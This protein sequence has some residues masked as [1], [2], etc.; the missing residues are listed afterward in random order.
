MIA[1]YDES[2]AL[3]FFKHFE[4]AFGRT[5]IKTLESLAQATALKGVATR[6]FDFCHDDLR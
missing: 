3:Y 4:N 2:D 5:N 1:V 6:A